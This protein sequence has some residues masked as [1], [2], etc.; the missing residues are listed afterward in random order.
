[1]NYKVILGLA[2]VGFLMIIVAS[3]KQM[4]SDIAR[5]N[6]NLNKIAKQVGVEDTITDQLKGLLLEGKR[7]EAVKKYRIATG[8]GLV[9]AKEYIDSLKEQEIKNI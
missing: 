9:E 8:A 6:A 5:I 1:M 3:I 7:I 4:Q 2:V